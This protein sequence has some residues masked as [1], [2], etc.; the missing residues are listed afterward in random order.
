MVT[1]TS[2]NTAI[3][4][5]TVKFVKIRKLEEFISK[6]ILAPVLHLIQCFKKSTVG[7]KATGQVKPPKS[8][9]GRHRPIRT[10][11]FEGAVLQAGDNN[12]RISTRRLSR[13]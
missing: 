9:C 6:D 11:N 8:D 4:V 2:Q 5:I 10:Q 3:C 7:I 12:P 1:F 13:T